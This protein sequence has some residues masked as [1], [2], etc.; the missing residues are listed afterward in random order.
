MI[1]IIP[2]RML[3]TCSRTLLTREVLSQTYNN[4]RRSFHQDTTF[5]KKFSLLTVSTKSS[6]IQ[7]IQSP[8]AKR[9]VA[10]LGK[11]Q[12][13]L[14]ILG[15]GW[16]GYK[17][18]Q[19]M[20][21]KH[22][23]VIVVSPRN[24]FVF[25]PLLA[26]SS[27]GTLEFRCILE[28][29]RKYSPKIQFYQAYADTIDLKQKI[30]YCTSNLERSKNKFSLNYDTLVIAAGANSNTFGIKGV[31]ENALFLKDVSD[32]R[33][34]RQRVIECFEHAG[35][36]NITEQE[37]FGLLH[38]AVVGGGPT[39]IEFSAELHDFI[40]EDM[41]RLYPDLINLVTMSVYDIAPQILGSFDQS[42]R[43]FATKKFTR[44]GI[45]IRT[46]RK[47]KEVNERKLIIEED[48]EVPYGMLVWATGLTDNPLTRSMGNQVVKDK[49]AKRLL[50]DGFLRVLDKESFQPIDNVYALGDCAS[51]QD[52]DLPATAQVAN[53]KAVYLRKVLTQ[54]A[55]DNPIMD[56]KPF[57]FLN[58]GS[59]AYIGKKEAVV[60]MTPVSNKAKESGRLAWIFWR[61]AYFTMT[62]SLRNKMLIP[63]YW[64]LTWLFGRDIS[65][66]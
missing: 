35:Q 13:R 26:S 57:K 61:S 25:T 14:V 44:K 34:I 22:Y 48:G 9:N 55:K 46:G 31:G 16:A 20:D 30:V 19:D 11:T 63:M 42:L 10:S 47:V 15:S 29:I 52:Y 4:V 45:K 18:I 60:D 66:F 64:I 21:T 6:S 56:I 37:A 36:P 62:V 23:E 53:Q 43:E 17:L 7:S 3:S 40:T 12:G 5:S 58:L 33:R 54:I 38:F 59:M 39:G 1:F 28:P 2:T 27:V 49:S 8:F 24:Y 50:T 41:A 65:R 32:A 51:I